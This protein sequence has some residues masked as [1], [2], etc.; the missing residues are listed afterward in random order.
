[1]RWII[2]LKDR[3]VDLLHSWLNLSRV[4]NPPLCTKGS[5]LKHEFMKNDNFMQNSPKG[6]RNNGHLSVILVR[7]SVHYGSIAQSKCDES[8]CGEVSLKEN[9]E[10]RPVITGKFARKFLEL[11]KDRANQSLSSSKSSSVLPHTAANNEPSNRHQTIK[12][13]NEDNTST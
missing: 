2:E 10:S 9:A 8:L 12:D 13:Q 5:Q 3:G 4:R 7:F 11:K 1:M 6:R